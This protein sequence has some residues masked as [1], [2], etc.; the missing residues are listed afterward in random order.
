MFYDVSLVSD[1]VPFYGRADI[2][3]E[4]ER[5]VYVVEI[6]LQW[7]E[8]H[9]GV[10]AQLAALSILANLVFNKPAEHAFVLYGDSAEVRHLRINSQIKKRTIDIAHKIIESLREGKKPPSSAQANQCTL[11]EYLNYCNDR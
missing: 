8:H 3:I 7:N 2:V 1:E 4:S 6:K 5:E 11:C 9:S 10:E